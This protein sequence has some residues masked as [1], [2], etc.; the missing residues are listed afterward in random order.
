MCTSQDQFIPKMFSHVITQ[1]VA[2]YVTQHIKN[3]GDFAGEVNL[4]LFFVCLFVFKIL[5]ELFLG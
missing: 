4:F 1:T 3:E 2:G 5:L